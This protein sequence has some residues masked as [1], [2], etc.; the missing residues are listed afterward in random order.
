M[1][2]QSAHPPPPDGSAYR[3]ICADP[4][5]RPALGGTWTAE[6]DRSRPQ[7]FYR[8]MSLDEICNLRVP[9]APQAHLYVWTLAQHPDWG[10]E[11]A[12]RWGFEPLIMLTWDKGR[13]GTG[14]FQCNTEHIIVARKGGRHGNPFGQVFGGTCFRWPAGRHSAKPPEFYDLVAKASPG[15]Y[16]ELFARVRRPGW[17]AWGNEVSSDVRIA[18]WMPPAKGLSPVPDAQASLFDLEADMAPA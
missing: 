10:C 2:A 3:T 5:W 14:R 6:A 13:P 18:G 4:P 11:V 15:P 9:S 1:N 7:R 17:H 8:T 12:R 16:L